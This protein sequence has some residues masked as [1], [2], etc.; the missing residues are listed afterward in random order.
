MNKKE[1][2]PWFVRENKEQKSTKYCA[3]LDFV[4]FWFVYR[5]EGEAGKKILA[6]PST[7][8]PVCFVGVYAT[9]CYS[10]RVYCFIHISVK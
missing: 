7:E 3:A 8:A 10:V 2:A 9:R 5:K 4:L 1:T 6:L